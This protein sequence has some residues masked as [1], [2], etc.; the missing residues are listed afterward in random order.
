MMR[1]IFVIG[2]LAAALLRPAGAAPVWPA[3]V[4]PDGAT[5]IEVGEQLNTNGMPL[6]V[7]AFVSPR[8]QPELAAWYR[9]RLGQPLME[10]LVGGKLVLGRPDGEFYITVQLEA[11]ARGTRGVV[12]VTHLRAGAERFAA[13]RDAALRLLARLPAGSRLVS[14]V[15]STDAGRLSRYLVIANGHHV[16]L[17]RG[18]VID[19]M[20][21][22]GLALQREARPAT[23]QS[24]VTLFFHG[25]GRDAMAVVSHTPQGGSTLL[26][27][28]L[29]TMERHQ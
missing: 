14:Q 17:N 10:N 16:D 22:D 26:L 27:H 21:E 19:L 4:L 3:P 5:P 12:A 23:G 13:T 8:P 20:R 25:A 6:R 2:C 29:S 9:T 7:H 1:L 28:T 24:G 18:R 11:L 15:T